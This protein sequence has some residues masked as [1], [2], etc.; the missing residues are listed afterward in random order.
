MISEVNH[1]RRGGCL[2]LGQCLGADRGFF[3]LLEY[4]EQDCYGDGAKTKT[5]GSDDRDD[6]AGGGLGFWRFGRRLKVVGL[7]LVIG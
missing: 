5:S 1:N 6:D 7:G 3:G 4:W 2:Y